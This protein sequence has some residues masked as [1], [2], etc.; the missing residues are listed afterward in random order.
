M[1]TDQRPSRPLPFSEFYQT[2]FEGEHQHPWNRLLHVAGTL[3][4][5]VVLAMAIATGSLWLGLTAPLVHV[6]PGIIGHRFLER[7]AEVSDLRVTRRDYPLWWFLV[8][9]HRM[10]FEILTGR[11]GRSKS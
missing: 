9:N 4:G 6:V 2:V 5:I 1:T 11:A 8:A 10:T 7:S 3:L